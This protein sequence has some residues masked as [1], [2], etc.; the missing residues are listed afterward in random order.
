LEYSWFCNLVGQRWN[1]LQIHVNAIPS[2]IQE[3][4][5]EGYNSY[6]RNFLKWEI[7]QTPL[8]VKI[9]RETDPVRSLHSYT[10]QV[11]YYANWMQNRIDWLNTYWN[12]DDFLF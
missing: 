4:A 3:K 12:S 7:F 9:N 5:A 8:N 6:C 2:S 1:D 11:D 10:E